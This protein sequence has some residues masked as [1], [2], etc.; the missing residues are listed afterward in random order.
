MARETAREIGR[1]RL[2]KTDRAIPSV[3]IANQK[4]NVFKNW[5]KFKVSGAI[6]WPGRTMKV[7]GEG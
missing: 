3:A 7:S 2:R 5:F 6:S 4:S 1:E